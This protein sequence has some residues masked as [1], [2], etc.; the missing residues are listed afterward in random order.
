MYKIG[1]TELLEY[2]IEPR[3]YQQPFTLNELVNDCSIINQ[4]TANILVSNV[5]LIPGQS[6][7]FGGNSQEINKQTFQ[8][9]QQ[10]GSS[11][12]FSVIVLLKR[13]INV[14]TEK[15]TYVKFR[16]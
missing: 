14:T 1:N 3:Q 2:F 6:F 11:G 5:I 15:D 4:G 7:D 16:N 8:V 9:T 12:T 10:A 13:Y